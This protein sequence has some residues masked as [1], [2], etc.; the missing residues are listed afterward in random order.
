MCLFLQGSVSCS[1]LVDLILS[2]DASLVSNL[3][4]NSPLCGSDHSVL[5][6]NFKVV[7]LYLK[8]SKVLYMYDKTNEE[9]VLKVV[10]QWKS[11]FNLSI[12]IEKLWRNFI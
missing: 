10:D 3:S 5:S 12:P 4:F 1:S 11:E 9:D 8:H 6:F 7:P 2:N